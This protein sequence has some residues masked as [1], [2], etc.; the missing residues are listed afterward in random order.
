MQKRR[1]SKSRRRESKLPPLTKF[2][3]KQRYGRHGRHFNNR[4][5]AFIWER[6]E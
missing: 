4:Q 5:Q 1:P 6:E 3:R 2:P